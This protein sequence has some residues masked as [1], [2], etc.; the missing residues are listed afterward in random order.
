VIPLK[1]ITPWSEP[2]G[3]N[4]DVPKIAGASVSTF[5]VPAHNPLIDLLSPSRLSTFTWTG[6]SHAGS[7][8][9]LVTVNGVADRLKPTKFDTA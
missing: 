4:R 5:T 2:Q 3:Y 7:A 6:H 1:H 8:V 9:F